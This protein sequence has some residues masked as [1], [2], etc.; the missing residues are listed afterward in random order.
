MS[1]GV[2]GIVT[3]G[4]NLRFRDQPI[5]GFDPE[6]KK[7]RN[8]LLQLEQ[9]L[10]EGDGDFLFRAD[11]LGRC[12]GTGRGGAFGIRQRISTVLRAL[13]AGLAI[14]EPVELTLAFTGPGV[15]TGAHFDRSPPQQ[16]SV[17]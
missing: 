8:P 11:R 2:A 16:F 4:T 9:G 6:R 3:N 5:N 13:G 17:R 10:P 15:H 12:R 7:E 1:L 14:T